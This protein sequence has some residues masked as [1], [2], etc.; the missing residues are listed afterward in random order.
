[1]VLGGPAEAPLAA[2][3][4]QARPDGLDLT[5]RTD[6]AQIGALAR[7]AGMA[8][9]NDTG[10]T[11][12]VAAAGCPTLA[13]FGEDSD[14][15]LCAPR[16]PAAGWVRQVPLASLGVEQALEGLAALRR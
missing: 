13:V 2:E 12:L 4:L 16:G 1:V 3:I 11:H 10:P 14:P 15:A 6:L 9:G 7:R 8:I 5:G